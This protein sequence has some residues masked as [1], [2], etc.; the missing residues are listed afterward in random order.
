MY[1]WNLRK[2]YTF[3]MYQDPV[4]VAAIADVQDSVEL[5]ESE[6]HMEAASSMSSRRKRPRNTSNSYL[7]ETSDERVNVLPFKPDSSL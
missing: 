4:L 5:E 1:F 2:D 3:D 7:P 6:D